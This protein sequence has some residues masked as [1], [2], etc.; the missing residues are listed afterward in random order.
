MG[1]TDAGRGDRAR[2]GC[3]GETGSAVGLID[4]SQAWQREG[5]GTWP[6]GRAVSW[7]CEWRP[8]WESGQ[9]TALGSLPSRHG[10]PELPA[11]P[12]NRPLLV[13]VLHLGEASWAGGAPVR[14]SAQPSDSP[15]C[16]STLPCQGGSRK[17][18]ASSPAPR[19]AWESQQ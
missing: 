1:S 11:A 2:E 19:S 14:G 3:L 5:P 18:R 17:G 6:E 12:T 7:D 16:R 10:H 8:S 9:Q 13:V 15:Q 4:R